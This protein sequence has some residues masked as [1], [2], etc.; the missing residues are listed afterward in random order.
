MLNKKKIKK[1]DKRY[2]NVDV[3]S[4]IIY[5]YDNVEKEFE[6][7]LQKTQQSANHNGSKNETHK[8]S[9]LMNEFLFVKLIKSLTC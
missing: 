2:D 8:N 4:Y 7:S 6:H 1:L 3:L 9:K 5:V